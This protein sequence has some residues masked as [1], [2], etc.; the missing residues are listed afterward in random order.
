LKKHDILINSQRSRLN[1]IKNNISKIEADQMNLHQL[2]KTVAL[3]TEEGLTERLL[4]IMMLM[5][6]NDARML[7]LNRELF[8]LQELLLP[9]RTF[10]TKLVTAINVTE[11]PTVPSI[12]IFVAGGALVAIFLGL[13][14]LLISR[15]NS[16][17]TLD[18]S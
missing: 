11:T 8:S 6:Q 1:E 4:L 2:K 10:N 12:P 16:E 15:S 5:G 18:L 13:V 7:T 14:W 17:P 9:A 3:S